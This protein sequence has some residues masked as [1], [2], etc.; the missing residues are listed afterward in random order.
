[1]S[2]VASIL[3]PVDNAVNRAA[4]A[5]RRRGRLCLLTQYFPPEMGAPQARLSELGERL[6]DFGWDVEALTALPNYPTG[7]VFAGYDARTPVVEQVGRIRTVRVPL[8]TAKTGF[9]KRMRSYLSFAAAA[10]R[11]GPRMCRRPDLLFVESPP[12]F[13]GYAARYLSWRWKCPYVF[14]V[15]DLW[16][17]SAIRMGIVKPGLATRMAERLERTLYRKAAGV[18]GQSAEI[19]AA[20]RKC[21][22]SVRTEVITNGV[23]PER[24]GRALADDAAR[25]LVGREPGPIFIFAGLLGLAQGL[26][27]ILDLAASLPAEAP[28]RFVLVGEGP[29]R[30]RLAERIE[31]ERI[32]R[33]KI[34]PA[35]PRERI[36]ALLAAADVALI[37]L[38]MSIP[39]AVP[40]KIYEAMATALPILL[41]ADGEPARRVQ[42][43]GCGV[44]VAPG[45]AAALRAAYLPLALDAAHREQLGAAGRIAAE[46]KYNRDQIA[47]RLDQFLTQLLPK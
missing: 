40:S 22:P 15:S 33:V 27:Q 28:G 26:D 30:E 1:L 46:T 2:D 47:E 23:D 17:E 9:T 6:I 8:Y 32:S 43:A 38:G 41:V 4:G 44:A 35:Q 12:L 37:T 18:T 45:D 10:S 24:F 42:E 5:A 34:I 39:G 13:I 11:Y 7:R 21:A 20:V 16:P 25:D 3:N 31:H 36:P 19:I 14:N 29:D